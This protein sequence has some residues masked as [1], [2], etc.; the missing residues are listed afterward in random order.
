MGNHLSK[1]SCHGRQSNHLA[2]HTTRFET[3]APHNT[4]VSTIAPPLRVD[5]IVDALY[6]AS[7]YLD[8]YSLHGSSFFRPLHLPKHLG[9]P[10]LKASCQGGEPCH[11]RTP[12]SI[13]YY[14]M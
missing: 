10:P 2:F 3:Y 12:P 14:L 13:S 5:V 6:N 9:N 4:Q 1:A 7:L 8:G 11:L